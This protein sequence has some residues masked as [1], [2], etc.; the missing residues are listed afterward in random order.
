LRDQAALSSGNGAKLN[1]LLGATVD[2][3]TDA[4][5]TFSNASPM[6]AVNN[7]GSFMKSAGL[8]ISLVAANF[9][10]SG[11]ISIK[12]GTL[13]FQGAWSQTAGSTTIDPG[14][15][16]SSSLLNID[17]G[18]LSGNGIIQAA[19]VNTGVTS[20][21]GSPGRLTIGTG[22][23][24]QQTPGGTLRVELGG[25]DP[26]TGYDQLIIGGNA[27]LGG[28]LELDSISSFVPQAGDQFEVLTAASQTG[29]FLQ[30]IGPLAS[31]TVWVPHYNGSNVV[32]AV[33]TLVKVTQPALVGGRISFSFA[34]SPGIS[35]VVQVSDSLIPS[36]WATAQQFSGDGAS[37]TFSDPSSQTQRYYRVLIQ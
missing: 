17:G 28:T 3:Q 23:T 15:V 4:L 34:T 18:T 27:V 32:V 16:L 2:F 29:H 30:V 36:N 13:Q 14:A 10:N 19:V 37:K 33:A 9:T 6:L 12:S 35:Y 7:S 31:G 22:Q 20:P 24:Y 25:H 8:Q 5:L 11:S 21:G 26:G 1:N